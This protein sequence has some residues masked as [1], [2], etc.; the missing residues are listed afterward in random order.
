[1]KSILALVIISFIAY[2]KS[3]AQI[4]IAVAKDTKGSSLEWSIVWNSGYNTEGQA[5][6]S[7]ENKG[8]EKV[9]VLTGGES[10]GHKLKSGY[11]VV[12]QGS[13]TSY[14]GDKIISFGMGASES[15]Y[16]E[17]EERAVSNLKQYDWS[18][19]DSDGYKISK[20]GTF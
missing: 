6:K 1:M 5:I 7:L 20:K 9:S 13:R 11:W 18:W 14:K 16:G 12:V 10:R 3:N 2:K 15:S 17:A 4:A 19:K 8:Y